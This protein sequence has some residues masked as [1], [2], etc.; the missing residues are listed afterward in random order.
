MFRTATASCLLGLLL[1]M[2]AVGAGGG[3]VAHG[4]PNYAAGSWEEFSPGSAS[5]GGISGKHL[6]AGYGNAN[7]VAAYN[8]LG[9]LYVAWIHDTAIDASAIYI[10]RFDGSDWTDVGVGS[11]N[12]DGISTGTL[13]AS[14]VSLDF[15]SAG[16]PY[17]AWDSW[18]E[19]TSL[20]CVY[21][22]RFDGANW[23]EVGTGSATGGGITGWRSW[24][25]RPSIALDA[26]DV[27]YVTWTDYRTG[28]YQGYGLKYTGGSWQEIVAGS[29][30]GNGLCPVA[31]QNAFPFLTFDSLDRM[32]LLWYGWE[33]TTSW[34]YLFAR[35]YTGGSW[36]ELGPGSSTR[37]QGVDPSHD[38]W[39]AAY[40]LGT[41]DLPVVFAYEYKN[42]TY[43]ARVYG[44]DG[45]HWL[46]YPRYE[47]GQLDPS[48]SVSG[49]RLVV[50][51][52]DIALG[53][54]NEPIFVWES[55]MDRLFA[56]T[57]RSGM[58]HDMGWDAE[59]PLGITEGVLSQCRAPALATRSDGQAVLVWSD[60]DVDGRFAVYVREF[61]PGAPAAV[62]ALEATSL[63]AAAAL[64]WRY[65]AGASD[66]FL[67]V[68]GTDDAFTTP[69]AGLT[70]PDG[71]SSGPGGRWC[72]NLS[73]AQNEFVDS[74]LVNGTAYSYHLYA[75]ANGRIY[76][77]PAACVSTPEA[78][79]RTPPAAPD[80]LVLATTD[81][82]R[83][84]WRDSISIDV[85]GVLL[86]RRNDPAFASPQDGVLYLDG[87]SSGPGGA[88][89][90]NLPVGTEVYR[91]ASVVAGEPYWYAIHARDTARNYSAALIGS[92][93]TLEFE[94]V[95]NPVLGEPSTAQTSWDQLVWRDRLHIG[96]GDWNNNTGPTHVLY[97]D[98][99]GDTFRGGF[100]VDD[101]SIDHYY[102]LDDTLYIPGVDARESWDWG[103]VYRNRGDGWAKLRTLPNAIH[104]FCLG[105]FQGK[106]YAGIRDWDSA[107][108][109][110]WGNVI[111]SDDDGATWTDSGIEYDWYWTAYNNLFV[112][113]G[114]LYAQGTYL[115]R[116]DGAAWERCEFP[117]S[118]YN[119]PYL[120]SHHS[121]LGYE[122]FVDHETRSL[123]LFT[124]AG[125]IEPPWGRDRFPHDLEVVGD[126]LFVMDC[127]SK[128][129]RW[130]AQIHSTTDL[131]QWRI[132]G[133]VE[134]DAFPR[135]LSVY[136]NRFYIGDEEGNYWRSKTAITPDRMAIV[137][138]HHLPEADVNVAYGNWLECSGGTVP[139]VTWSVDAGP[140]PAGLQL[141]P[142]GFLWGSPTVAG[143]YAWVARVECGAAFTTKTLEL[144]VNPPPIREE[145]GLL[146][147]EAE[148]FDS[149]T[150]GILNENWTFANSTA[151]YSGTG[152]LQLLPDLNQLN[153]PAW[154]SARWGA[155]VS[156]RLYLEQAGTHYVWLRGRAPNV[157]GNRVHCGLD[158]DFTA[159]CDSAGVFS[160]TQFDWVTSDSVERKRIELVVDAPGFHTFS[161]SK[162]L[163]GVM[164][165][166]VVVTRDPGYQPIGAGPA[167][168]QR[169]TPFVPSPTP[170]PTVTPTPTQTATAT[171]SPTATATPE[172]S[173]TF[174]GSGIGNWQQL[175]Y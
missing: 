34:D 172:P 148:S 48:D 65:P 153:Q 156:W 95:G 146:V 165:D 29:N 79:D 15:D 57:H 23:V 110:Y 119:T 87:D 39:L 80:R 60:H 160:T 134:L 108:G 46:D 131:V 168:T 154:P 103:N 52:G 18:N 41:N 85:E 142:A 166:K 42:S 59:R 9:H 173:P 175:H 97:Y 10:R 17:L 75:F 169:L 14:D 135:T 7:P 77:A 86:M 118:L 33:S 81:T 128:G 54:L 49:T 104:V 139:D 62:S 102:A 126:E 161:L 130:I 155:F 28:K 70:Y 141:A 22:R 120:V 144:V 58:W 105:K 36:E 19:G 55:P 151:G 53:P 20:G 26:A 101:E 56:R 35:R 64:R 72:R 76:A 2:G 112:H 98:R 3:G 88:W 69:V 100:R 12:G 158:R 82:I 21:V 127:V 107:T 74:P 174:P 27:P 93:T 94:E 164:I 157:N 51:D 116:F 63:D 11:S 91:D 136:D 45:A 89:C 106:L 92:A 122:A 133:G 113:A 125:P 24:M 13:D 8:S 114:K 152:Y 44:F 117:F 16:L 4:S 115:F 143:Q 83:L 43:Y 66:G 150:T 132:R 170:T 129:G 67:L 68:R 40:R 73:E 149:L 78:T 32:V 1:W 121:F 37:Y 147:F 5:G 162:C 138:P 84:Q 163:D 31:N 50:Y 6:V 47:E 96:Y 167:P 90:R 159:Q 111:V 109:D 71:E 61:V 137:S 123:Q 145:T 30:S 171:P 25:W 124:E 99:H 38:I 140:L